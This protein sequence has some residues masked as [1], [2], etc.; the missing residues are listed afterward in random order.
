MKEKI[1]GS[2]LS[3]RSAEQSDK[4]KFSAGFVRKLLQLD[5]PDLILALV[6]LELCL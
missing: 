2:I 5:F 4:P 3:H 1:P 6:T